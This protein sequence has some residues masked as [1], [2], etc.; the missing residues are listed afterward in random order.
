MVT[1]LMFLLDGRPLSLDTAF[2]HDGVQ[3]PAIWLRLASPE[4][5]EAIGIVEAPNPA[6]YDQ[7]FYWGISEDGS[8]IEKDLSQ[9]KEQWTAQVKTTAK[10]LMDSTDW[11]VTR[12]AEPGGKPV[13]QAVLDER[14]LIRSKSDEKEDA[15]EQANT[16]AELAA[17]VTGAGFWQWN[18]AS[19][20]EADAS[21]DFASGLGG[22]SSGAIYGGE[23]EDVITL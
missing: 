5:R 1:R 2:T 4:E 14:N 15:I 11:M 7:R 9:L 13:P 8:L 16:V 17:Y 12:S 6:T 10:T 3:Y 20:E 18:E 23:G 21:E 22:I 19:S